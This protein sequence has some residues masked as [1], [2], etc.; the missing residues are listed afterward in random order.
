MTGSTLCGDYNGFHPLEHASCGRLLRRQRPQSIEWDALILVRPAIARRGNRESDDCSV[1][2]ASQHG[3]RPAGPAE[4]FACVLRPESACD[5]DL[6]PCGVLRGDRSGFDGRCWRIWRRPTSWRRP[7]RRAARAAGSAPRGAADPP[8]W[9]AARCASA[10]AALSAAHCLEQKLA[11]SAI[12]W[13]MTTLG[14]LAAWML[15]TSARV[16]AQ[17]FAS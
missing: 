15:L 16:A 1:L 14:T 13:S 3:R 6:P 9:G 8:R 10:Y 5:E 17:K 2:G 11:T 4:L 7:A 12:P